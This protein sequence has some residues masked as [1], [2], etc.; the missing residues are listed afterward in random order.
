[1][2]PRQMEGIGR[3][4]IC[5]ATKWLL[6][7]SDSSDSGVI[8]AR[9]VGQGDRLL[10]GFHFRGQFCVLC[11]EGPE[12]CGFGFQSRILRFEG[13]D[14]FRQ[15]LGGAN[16]EHRDGITI[17]AFQIQAL[18][19]LHG[20]LIAEGFFR[21]HREGFVIDHVGHD[22]EFGILFGEPV[23]PRRSEQHR[24]TALSVYFSKNIGSLLWA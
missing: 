2:A 5:S 4:V 14:L 16:I 9:L 20:D 12:S 21:R 17:D 18:L 22:T 3:E 1:M 6:V 11:F 24:S 23:L 15:F 7:E 8:V 10:Q 19:A 13:F